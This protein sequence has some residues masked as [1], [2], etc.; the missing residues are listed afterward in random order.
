MA[1]GWRLTIRRGSEVKR[2]RVASL[3]EALDAARDAAEVTLREGGLKAISVLRDFEPGQRVHARL[4]LSGPG[5]LRSAEGGLDV[6]GDGSI[7]AYKGAIRKQPL[8]TETLSEAIEALR[9][10]LSA[11]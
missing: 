7:V 9:E 2:R 11:D 6:M 8:G 4:E 3:E 5:W 10:A 1:R